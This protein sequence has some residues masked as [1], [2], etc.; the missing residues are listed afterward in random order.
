MRALVAVAKNHSEIVDL[1]TLVNVVGASA[2]CRDMLREK[3]PDAIFEALNSN[4]LLSG[5]GLNQE[6]NLK[7]SSD[8]RW[9]SH[10]NCLIS[11]ENMFPSVIDV[12]KI[13]RTD[14]SG[15][16][17]KFEVKPLDKWLYRYNR[18][19]TEFSLLACHNFD[20]YL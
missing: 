16:E 11:L 10:Y 5:K 6:T 4:E 8:T 14:G 17:Q 9:S 12:F 2:E 3:H 20:A 18:C 13:V 15:Y 19:T 7:Q 1:F